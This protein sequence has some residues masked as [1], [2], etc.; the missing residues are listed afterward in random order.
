MSEQIEVGLTVNGRRHRAATTPRTTL[1]DFLR[2]E[3]RL[4]AT[5]LGCEQG[6]CGACTVLLDGVSVL[7]CLILAV[8][9]DGADIRTA[10]GL[11]GPDGALS[12]LADALQAE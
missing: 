1:A 7:S 6:V 12:P 9:A 8:Q 4:T 3:C 10:E 11:T 5:H 2:S